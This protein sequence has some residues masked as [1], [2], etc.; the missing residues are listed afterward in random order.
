MTAWLERREKVQQHAALIERQRRPATAHDEG[1]ARSPIGPL[2]CRT[3]IIKMTQHPTVKA[4][5]FNT[6][7]EKYGAVEFQDTLADYI[8]Q[9]NH[10]GASAATLRARAADT[11]IPFRSVPV[12]HKIKFT[13]NE[14]IVDAIHVRPEQVDA[15]GCTTP[16]R[17]DTALVR[18]QRSTHREWFLLH[19]LNQY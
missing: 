16:P 4:V 17:F 11:L 3:R 14:E 13:V 6:L 10:P 2:Q 18:S 15:S 8:A 5:S 7:A 1:L 12:F 19:I 9:V